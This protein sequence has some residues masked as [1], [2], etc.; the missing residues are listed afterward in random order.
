MEIKLSKNQIYYYKKVAEK[1]IED[2]KKKNYIQ[3]DT[4]LEDKYIVHR[5]LVITSMK[6][7]IRNMIYDLLSESEIFSH[8]E[9]NELLKLIDP[10]YDKI[11]EADNKLEY[12]YDTL[13]RTKVWITWNCRDLT[14]Q[15]S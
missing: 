15:D 7:G 9:L 10:I 6:F 3:G 1:K 14:N 2:I 8:K 5:K 4:T 13:I 11:V 12:I